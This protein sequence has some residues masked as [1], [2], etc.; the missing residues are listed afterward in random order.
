MEVAIREQ[1]GTE[2]AEYARNG[3]IIVRGLFTREECAT[4]KAETKRLVAEKGNHGGVFVGLAAHS[5]VFADVRHL[6]RLLDVLEILLGPDIEFLSDK[7]VFKSRE[8]DFGSPWHQDWQYWKGAHKVSAWVALDDATR[9]TGCLKLLPGSHKNIVV[10][11]GVA[12]EGEG[13]GHRLREDA[14]DESQ[15]VAAPCA[16]GDAV[17]FH[18]LLLHASYPNVT[19][20]DRYSFITTYRSAAEPDFQYSWSVASEIVRGERRAPFLHDGL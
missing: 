8:K 15:V 1:S 7:V 2:A 5:P 17:F 19:G 10:H 12:P 13:F 18:D 20:A 4:L 11:D 16:V 14:V 6:P 3:Y 9:E